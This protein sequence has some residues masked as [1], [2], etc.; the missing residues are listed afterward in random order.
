MYHAYDCEFHGWSQATFNF[1]NILLHLQGTVKMASVGH[2]VGKP[3]LTAALITWYDLG[4]FLYV[5]KDF[6]VFPAQSTS[7]T[8]MTQ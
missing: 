4:L 2:A 5:Q 7:C 1:T 8:L 3:G 6:N